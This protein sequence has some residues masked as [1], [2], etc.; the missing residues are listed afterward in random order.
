VLLMKR[1]GGVGAGGWFLPG[2]HLEEG[3]RPVEAAVREVFE[4]TGI[5][6][7]PAGLSLAD[8]MS[9]VSGAAIAHNLVYNAL[10][11]EGVEA[12]VND[13]HFVAR[14][15]EPQAA[16]DRFYEESR[17]RAL[18]VPEDA[19]ELAAEVARVLRS[20][21][22]ARGVGPGSDERPLF[23]AQEAVPQPGD[24]AASSAS[25]SA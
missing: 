6:L 18:N 9:Y 12:I 16:I 25:D 7:D 5:A 14:W 21:M 1:A 2:G 8:V 13:E 19:I 3:E 4:E 15:Y 22:R 10:A 23:G 20:A 11:P 24:G 17:L